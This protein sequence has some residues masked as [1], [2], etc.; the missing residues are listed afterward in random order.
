MPCS[1]QVGSG[2]AAPLV[3]PLERTNWNV[4]RQAQALSLAL[5]VGQALQSTGETGQAEQRLQRLAPG[6][7]LRSSQD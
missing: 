5:A 2:H 7:L 3:N 4:V 1:T 6:Q